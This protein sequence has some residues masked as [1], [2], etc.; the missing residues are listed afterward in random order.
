MEILRF[1]QDDKGGAQDDKGGAQ[2][3][4]RTRA[5]EKKCHA[6]RSEAS[7]GGRS[8]A[9]AQDDRKGGQFGRHLPRF[10]GKSASDATFKRG[11]FRGFAGKVRQMFANIM[12]WSFYIS[13]ADQLFC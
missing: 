2:D 9:N 4:R 13:K 1:A 3:E 5:N 12:F 10:C 8:F 6:E 7:V 11:I